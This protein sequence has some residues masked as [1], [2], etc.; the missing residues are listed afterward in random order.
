[1]MRNGK[2]YRK[3]CIACHFYKDKIL[4]TYGHA[5]TFRSGME[6]APLLVTVAGQWNLGMREHATFYFFSFY[7]AY[8]FIII[9]YCFYNENNLHKENRKK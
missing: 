6:T 5:Y 7:I 3:K 9:I 1:M 8:I 2:R 4:R